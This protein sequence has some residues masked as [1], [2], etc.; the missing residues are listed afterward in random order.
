[1]RTRNP[2]KT[3]RLASELTGMEGMVEANTWEQ[4]FS[5]ATKPV[6]LDPSLA[7]QTLPST[8][9]PAA[10][11]NGKGTPKATLRRSLLPGRAGGG[12]AVRDN[13]TPNKAGGSADADSGNG[14][15]GGEGEAKK[16]KG[17]ALMYAGIIVLLTLLTVYVW[18]YSAVKNKL[19]YVSTSTLAV[20]ALI[21]IFVNQF[22]LSSGNKNSSESGGGAGGAGAAHP[23][24]AAI[25]IIA[26]ETAKKTS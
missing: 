8:G 5:I 15:S 2:D 11:N 24:A 25:A 9:T 22:I 10:P 17:S 16:D 1:M 18:K 23:H 20:A 26:E 4:V 13:K 12:L 3:F 6:G 7:P 21:G 14:G 19:L